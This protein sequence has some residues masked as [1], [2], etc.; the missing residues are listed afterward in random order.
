MS[1]KHFFHTSANQEPVSAS[2]QSA[3]IRDF[4]IKTQ[5]FTNNGIKMTTCKESIEWRNDLIRNKFMIAGI[6]NKHHIKL[7]I[8]YRQKEEVNTFMLII[9][10]MN[11]NDGFPE[12]GDFSLYLIVDEK[13]VLELEDVS[14]W[15]RMTNSDKVNGELLSIFAETVEI[16]LSMDEI[17][18]IVHAQKI[19]FSIRF[20]KG[21]FHGSLTP[22]QVNIFKGFYHAVYDNHFETEALY[23][24][25]IEM[26]HQL[27]IPG[28]KGL[29]KTLHSQVK[30]IVEKAKCYKA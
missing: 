26:Q 12:M 13:N 7:S 23:K 8:E 20:N 28:K 1:Q 21:R 18:S 22:E 24:A 19:D 11:T 2:E 29:I 14:S 25:V 15:Q 5:S 6:N 16:P 17:H 30:K 27:N 3:T 10:Y 9:T 4:Y